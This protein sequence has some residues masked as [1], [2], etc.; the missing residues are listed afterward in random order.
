MTSSEIRLADLVDGSTPVAWYEA[1]ALVH[2]VGRAVMDQPALGVPGL[3]GLHLGSDGIVRIEPQATAAPDVVPALADLLKALL[4]PSSPER[5]AALAD[6]SLTEVRE[7]A[8]KEFLAALTFFCRPDEVGDLKMLAERASSTRVAA[9]R[10]AALHALTERARQVP[11]DEHT[12]VAKTRKSFNTRPLKL[13][14]AIA[15]AVAVLAV[16]AWTL[17]QPLAASVEPA[18]G[19]PVA[20]PTVAQR[21]QNVVASAAAVVKGSLSAPPPAAEGRGK[22]ITLRPPASS[23]SRSRLS[24]RTE[25]T[26]EVAPTSSEAPSNA[27]PDDTPGQGGTHAPVTEAVVEESRPAGPP[28]AAADTD[29]TPPAIV[30]AQMPEVPTGEPPAG[31]HGVLELV[32]DERGMVTTVRLVSPAARHQERMMVSAAKTWRFAPATRDGHPVTYRLRMPVVW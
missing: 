11:P 9:A 27:R 1:V 22:D 28:F 3:T 32:I 21:V 20:Q 26:P 31:T 6:S 25:A 15:M 10:A 16:G 17:K 7:S 4:P 2:Q 5:L 19:D 24:Q 18:N 23:R 29:V 14:A 13:V 12:A 8:L 30:R